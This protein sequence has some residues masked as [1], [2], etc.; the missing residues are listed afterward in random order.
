MGVTGLG[1][2]GV[3]GDV[4]ARSRRARGAHDVTRGG[5]RSRRRHGASAAPRNPG[6]VT[7][8]RRKWVTH[9]APPKLQ[10]LGG[11]GRVEWDVG[12]QHTLEG[13]CHLHPPTW[14]RDRL[15][16]GLFPEEA[17]R[18]AEVLTGSDLAEWRRSLRLSQEALAGQLDLCERT[19]RRAETSPDHPLTPVLRK[20]LARFQRSDLVP[21]NP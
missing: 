19:I 5:S 10:A 17:G 12:E 13:R 1:R 4:A 6:W 9:W 11:L 15:V 3:G 7:P 8:E 20:A 16:H 18:D 14:V 2:S 21:S